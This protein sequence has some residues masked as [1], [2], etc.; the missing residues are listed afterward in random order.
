MQLTR[1][2]RSAGGEAMSERYT[3][4]KFG[5]AVARY[6]QTVEHCDTE[7]QARKVA[8]MLLKRKNL[9][10]VPMWCHC[11]RKRLTCCDVCKRSVATGCT[12][13]LVVTTGARQCPPI[14]CGRR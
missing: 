9:R 13:F 4:R 5:D 2:R 1:C 12:F 8:A 6:A 3:V 7:Q 11:Q 10:G 14:H